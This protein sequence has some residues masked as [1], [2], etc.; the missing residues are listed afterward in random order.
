MPF[1]VDGN[2]TPSEISEAINY[3]MANLDSGVPADAYAVS[4]NPSTG[5]VSNTIGDILQYQYRYLDVKY[6]DDTNGLNFSDN[7]QGRGYFGIRNTEEVTESTNP[8]DYTWFE[9]TG[10]FGLTKVLWLA[11]TGG[12]HV[13]YAISADAPDANQNWIVAP[14]QA[15]DLDN[16]FARYEQYMVV[17][18]ADNSV[19]AN[20]SSSPSGKK[21]WGI[22]TSADGSVATDPTAYQWSP[23]DFGTTYHLYYRSFGGR[24]IAFSQQTYQPIGYIPVTDV[25]I[26][27]DVSTIGAVSSIG[28]ISQTPLILQSP[29]RYLLIR[30]GDDSAG[31]GLS[32]DPTGKTYFGI[33]A[34]DVLTLDNN[35]ADYQW[36]DAGGTFITDVNLWSKTTAD[37]LVQ[38]SLTLAAPDESA[39][40]NVTSDTSVIDPNID[41]YARTGT[42]VANI[43]SPTSGKIGFSSIGPGGVVNLN[44]NPYGQ[45]SGT[46]GYSINP[47]TTA[48]ITVDEFGR[49][50]QTGALD[51]VRFSSMLTHA[52]AGQTAFSFSNAQPNQILV[53]RNGSFLVPGT[54]YTRTSTT[55][56]FVSACA[57]NDVIAIYYVRLIDGTT[58]ADKVPFVTTTVTLTAGQTDISST[59][60]DGS[61]LLFINGMLIVDL[62]YSYLGSNTGYHLSTPSTGGTCVIV[63]FAFNNGGALIF[64]ENYTTTAFGTTNVTFPTQFYRNSSLIWLNGALLRPT[65]D[66][67]LSGSGSLT[68][69]YTSVGFLNISNQPTQFCSFNSSGEASVSSI[70][71]AGVLGYDIPIEIEQ[72]ET[73]ASMFAKMQARIEMLE[74][75]L[76]GFIE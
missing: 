16:P 8:A 23:F 27:L 24:N 75:K 76:E 69:S 17:R 64:G 39:W 66:Y 25:A 44:L 41:V 35:P 68:Y 34:S 42:V 65:D 4:N 70:S 28:I 74:A 53:F 31:T 45:G 54:D 11:I 10:G 58:S 7:P 73:I 18:Y 38:F 33:Q 63:S 71:A 30:Y 59:Y 40:Y 20:I 62:D 22:Y 6:A 12:R 5:F 57:L 14:V 61:E 43:T 60:A 36:F 13:A 48:S 37:N 21:F 19:G 52:T 72:P 56:T 9:V 2:P 32:S 46:G 1:F 15:I 50:V 67:T 51:Q 29:Y 47:L 55:V 49:V 26:N 3:L